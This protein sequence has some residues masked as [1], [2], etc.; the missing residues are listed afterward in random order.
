MCWGRSCDSL[1]QVRGVHHSPLG[2]GPSD[3]HSALP[4]GKFPSPF[5]E[6]I[7]VPWVLVLL[8]RIAPFPRGSFPLLSGFWGHHGFETEGMSP[9]LGKKQLRLR[10]D[11]ITQPGEGKWGS[12]PGLSNDRLSLYLCFFPKVSA[13]LVQSPG[14]FRSH[15]VINPKHYY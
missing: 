11:A 7:T 9:S 15:G 6:F 5:G 8:M 14:S 3:A 4:Q 1:V 13:K 10:Q 12:E 2:S